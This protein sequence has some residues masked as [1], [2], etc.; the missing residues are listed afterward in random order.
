MAVELQLGLGT[1]L[2]EYE[3]PFIHHEGGTA[4]AFVCQPPAWSGN[5]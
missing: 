1:M 5:C 4:E 3:M 2:S